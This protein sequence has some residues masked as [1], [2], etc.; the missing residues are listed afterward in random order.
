V[1]GGSSIVDPTLSKTF[2]VLNAENDGVIIDYGTTG[3]R[4]TIKSNSAWSVRNNERIGPSGTPNDIYS[5]FS[6]FVILSVNAKATE[7]EGKIV[8]R[9]RADKAVQTTAC[10]IDSAKNMF[11]RN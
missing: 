3:M 8:V 11:E 2:V 5:I 10:Y 6:K 4:K 7:V 1:K 9:K